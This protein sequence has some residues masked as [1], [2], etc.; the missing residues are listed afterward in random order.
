MHPDETLDKS[1]TLLL[2]V[3]VPCLLI[4]ASGVVLYNLGCSRL[5]LRLL[6]STEFTFID[7]DC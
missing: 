1:S 4:V 2:L 5:K 7:A 3:I 6:G